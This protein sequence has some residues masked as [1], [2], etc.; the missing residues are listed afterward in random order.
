MN[1]KKKL[2]FSAFLFSRAQKREKEFEMQKK[3]D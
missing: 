3:N 2:D 1:G